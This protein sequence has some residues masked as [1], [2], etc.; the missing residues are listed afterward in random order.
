MT[1]KTTTGFRSCLQQLD[2][3]LSV[4]GDGGGIGV[5]IGVEIYHWEGLEEM[6]ILTI[7]VILILLIVRIL[8][9]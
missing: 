8:S 6:Y 4:F 2:L 7:L 1:K 3:S 9:P 5:V